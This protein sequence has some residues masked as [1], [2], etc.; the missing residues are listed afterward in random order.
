MYTKPAA[1]KHTMRTH[2]GQPHGRLVLSLILGALI[3][4]IQQSSPGDSFRDSS[5]F[6]RE[7]LIEERTSYVGQLLKVVDTIER[8]NNA[9]V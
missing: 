2:H 6:Q 8:E 4:E 5:L 3:P 9:K 1:I 7:Q